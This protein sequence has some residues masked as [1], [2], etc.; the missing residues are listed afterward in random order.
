MRKTLTEHQCD[1]TFAL[2]KLIDWIETFTLYHVKIQELN[3]TA[4]TQEEYVRTGKSKTMY[5]KHLNRL[6]A[7]LVLYNP[8]T[9]EVITY[10]EAFRPIGEYWERLGG[11]WGGRFGLEGLPKGNQAKKLGWDVGHYEWI[12]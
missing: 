7:D 4:A 1:F 11:R 3:R 12:V 10:G 8:D 5:S 6:A 9:K 2:A